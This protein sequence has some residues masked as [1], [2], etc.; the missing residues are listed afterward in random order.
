MTAP[1]K[2]PRKWQRV[3][4]AFLTGRSYNRFE[5]ERELSDHCLPTTAATLQRMGVTIARCDEVIPGFQG[6]PT[7]CS[8]YWLDRAPDN[9]ARAIA[10]L[11]APAAPKRRA[12]AAGIGEHPG[13]PADAKGSA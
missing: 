12:R 1:K 5:S 11:N 3:L 6:N 4:E 7:R 10:L 9:V 13:A 8:R 2:K